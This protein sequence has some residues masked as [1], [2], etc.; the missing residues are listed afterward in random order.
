MCNIIKFT[1]CF[2]TELLSTPRQNSSCVDGPARNISIQAC[3]LRC[4]AAING[5]QK[6]ND[7]Q[8]NLTANH[9][10]VEW[11][12]HH[13]KELHSYSTSARTSMATTVLLQPAFITTGVTLHWQ[14][15]TLSS[16]KTI[17]MCH[18]TNQ[19]SPSDFSVASKSGKRSRLGSGAEAVVSL[20]KVIHDKVVSFWQ[21]KA[22]EATH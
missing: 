4:G 22:A 18:E 14:N 15:N 20:E 3:S 12:A 9:A 21:N 1:Q 17:T 5:L 2:Q 11:L 13:M 6:Q 10:C 8:L 19:S 7:K 16:V